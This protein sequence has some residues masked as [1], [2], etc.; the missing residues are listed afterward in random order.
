MAGPTPHPNVERLRA[1]YAD[2]GLLETYAAEDMVLHAGGSRGIMAG[3]YVGR[4]AVLAKEM[5]LYRR[6]GGTLVITLDHVVAN[7]HFGAALGRFG[8]HRDGT[9]FEGEVC[10]LWRFAD[11]LIVEH[12]ENCADWPAAERFFV[13]GFGETSGV[14][15]GTGQAGG[16]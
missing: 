6:S 2:F 4:K 15:A 10:G 13:D 16:S 1:V 8:A 9:R 5:E 12:W 11:G 14:P 3:D 7:D